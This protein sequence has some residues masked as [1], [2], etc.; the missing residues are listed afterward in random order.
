VTYRQLDVDGLERFEGQG[1]FY[2]PLTAQDH[3][4][5]ADPVVIVGGN[6]SAGQAA[7][8]LAARGHPVTIV[9]RGD[10]LAASMSQ[11]LID[12]IHQQP[13]IDLRPH[14][15]VA[16]LDGASRLESV[17][18]KDLTTSHWTSQATSSWPTP[19]AR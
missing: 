19:S 2:T 9:I 15:V 14:S 10:D 1:V 8:F 6:N 16:E 12:R 17:V 7:T 11:Y 5:L 18:V 4:A 3:V 13:T